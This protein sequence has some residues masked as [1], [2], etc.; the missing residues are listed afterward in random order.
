[1]MPRSALRAS[2][3]FPRAS[4]KENANEICRLALRFALVAGVVAGVLFQSPC[5]WSAFIEVAAVVLT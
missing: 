3:S 1:M 4:A 2:V 5:R